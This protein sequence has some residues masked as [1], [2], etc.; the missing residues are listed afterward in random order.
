MLFSRKPKRIQRKRSKG[1]RMPTNTI[2]V[3][4]PSTWAN[5]FITA[6]E[7][8]SWLDG[9]KETEHESERR[10]ILDNLEDLRGKNLACWCPSGQ[11]CHADV[12]LKLANP[13]WI[14]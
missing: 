10:I 11:T 6:R 3:G 13:R 14:S 8:K 5:P 2:Y 7:Y 1:W 4:R 9:D 12:L